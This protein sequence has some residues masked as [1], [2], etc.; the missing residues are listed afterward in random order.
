VCSSVTGLLGAPQP[1]ARLHMNRRR[2]INGTSGL[3][4]AAKTTLMSR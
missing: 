2:V 1:H 4:R 3:F